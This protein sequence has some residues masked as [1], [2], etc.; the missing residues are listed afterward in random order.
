MISD[1]ALA[2]EYFEKAISNDGYLALSNLGSM[3]ENGFDVEKD[4]IKAKELYE[5]TIDK[6]PKYGFAYYCLGN[7]YK[8]GKG[9]EKDIDKAL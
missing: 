2:K 9:V 7:L 8:K 3:Y 6:D 4:F 5:E 1:Y